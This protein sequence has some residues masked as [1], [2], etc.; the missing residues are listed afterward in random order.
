M[1]PDAYAFVAHAAPINSLV[2]LLSLRC[3]E[4][5]DDRG[6]RPER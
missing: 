5:L 6:G 1:P 4:I 2:S 3:A